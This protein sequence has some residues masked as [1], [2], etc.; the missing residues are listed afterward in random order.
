[1]PAHE[2]ALGPLFRGRAV[3]SYNAA[4]MRFLRWLFW[5]FVFFA[6]FA[7]SLNNLQTIVVHWFFGVDW[8]APLVIVVLVAFALGCAFGVMA[9]VPSWWRQRRAAKQ[10]LAAV[11]A[12]APA[13]AASTA[14]TPSG[15]GVEP[16]REV[17]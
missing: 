15:F 10:A 1:M 3:A 2:G 5:A 16:P 13:P 17:L 9:M 11:P 8:N 7:F 4:A 14:G 12:P 6:L